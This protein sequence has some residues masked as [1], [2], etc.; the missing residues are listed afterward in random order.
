M[1]IP[2]HLEFKGNEL[3]DER[4]RNAALNCAVFDGPL[5]PV[6]FQGLARFVLLRKKQEKWDAADTG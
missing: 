6:N 5:S 4:A 1:R 2:S 3:V